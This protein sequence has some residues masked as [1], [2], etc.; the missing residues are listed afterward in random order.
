SWIS[1]GGKGRGAVPRKRYILTATAARDLEE[2]TAWSLARWD[3]RLTDQ[4]LDDLHRGAQRLAENYRFF[5][6]RKEL[7]GGTGLS[8]YPVREH[9][10]VYMPVAER[11]IIIVS[12]IRQGRDVPAILRRGA[13][14][15]RHELRDIAEKAARGEILIPGRARRTR[16]ASPGGGRRRRDAKKGR[17]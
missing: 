6:P 4:Y 12:F 13:Y 9:Y 10:I 15:I 17:V 3:E 11:H 2:L 8:L 5:N 1:R 16:K 7:A 14:Q